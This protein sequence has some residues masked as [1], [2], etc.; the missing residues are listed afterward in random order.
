MMEGIKKNIKTE[1]EIISYLQKILENRKKAVPEEIEFYNN[2]ILAI[3]DKLDTLNKTIPDLLKEKKVYA[4][5]EI[6]VSG[7]EKENFLKALEIEESN[8]KSVKSIEKIKKEK[9]QKVGSF[10]IIA[11]KIFSNLATQLREKKFFSSL[12]DSLRKSNMPL[13]LTTYISVILF[14][15]LI[16]LIAGLAI[17]GILVYLNLI[18]WAIVALF[19]PVIAFFSVYL[20]PSSQVSSLKTKIDDELTFAIIHMSAVSGSGVTPLQIFQIIAKSSDYPTVGSEMRKI[21]NQINLYG[22]SLV[23]SL[24]SIAKTTASPR[25]SEL[26]N[27]IATTLASG[28][29]L[30]DY[31]NKNA[32]DTLTDYKLRRRRYTT[33]SE[34]YADI[35]TGLLIAAPLIF[36]LILVLVNV[37]GS[38]VGGMSPE[39]LALLGIGGV[40]V[41]NIAF[42]VFLEISQPAG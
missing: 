26:F 37:L 35:Y 20:Y 11:S 28:G 17:A 8:L 30:K 7:R 25:L 19:L 23:N 27:G 15:T 42:M 10:P 38:A 9:E 22:Y 14:S 40:V 6:F 21:V 18:G 2:M 34:T 32:A 1:K 13:L 12:N 39:T 5:G 3:L 29:E 24:R 16:V 36:M 31:L 41:L 4:V 33:I